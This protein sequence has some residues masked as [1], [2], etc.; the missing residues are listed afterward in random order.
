MDTEVIALYKSIC[1]NNSLD[2]GTKQVLLDEIR[3][4]KPASE[5]R[6]N[7]RYVIW[8]LAIVAL[9]SPLT[10]LLTQ[11]TIEIPDGV[12]SLSSTAVGALAAFI[13]SGPKK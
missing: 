12:L 1:E 5:N 11:A 4:L 10:M 7:F 13:T 3:K 6:W 2:I 8:A 9:A